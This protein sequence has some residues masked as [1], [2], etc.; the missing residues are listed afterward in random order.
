LGRLTATL[1]ETPGSGTG[2]VRWAY[3]VNNDLLQ[4]LGAG[5]TLTETWRVSVGANAESAASTGAPADQRE[6]QMALLAGGG[7]VVTWTE[8]RPGEDYASVF[9]RVFGTDGAPAGA[10]FRVNTTVP[11]IGAHSPSVAALSGGGFVVVWQSDGDAGALPG[12]GG[13]FSYGV[14]GQVFDAGGAKLGGEF[15]ANTSVVGNQTAPQAVAL[16]DDRFVV[17]WTS[18][19]ERIDRV[20]EAGT[21]ELYFPT[22]LQGQAFRAGPLGAARAIDPDSGAPAAEFR[23]TPL[24]PPAGEALLPGVE[25]STTLAL[26]D[27]GFVTAW[28][29]TQGAARF[30]GV[31]FQAYDGLGRPVGG[32]V[33]ANLEDGAPSSAAQFTALG[34]AA[35][36][37]GGF[38]LV[39]QRGDG[40]SGV[41]LRV[42]EAD[43]SARSAVVTIGGGAEFVLPGAIRVAALADGGFV[44]VWTGQNDNLVRG[45]VFSADGDAVG[46]RFLADAGGPPG[47]QLDPR[48]A[49]TAEGGFVLLWSEQAGLDVDVYAQEFDA[50]GAARAPGFPVNLQTPGAQ[51]SAEIIALPDGGFAATWL[52]H[53][54]AGDAVLGRVVDPGGAA[55]AATQLVTVTLNGVNDAPV[56]EALVLGQLQE[57]GHNVAGAATLFDDLSAAGVWTDAD[58]GEAQLLRVVRAGGGGGPQAALAFDTATGEAAVQGTYGRLFIRADGGLRYVLDQGDA[59]TQ[60]LFAGQVAQEV[61]AYTVANGAGAGN[62]AA[63]TLTVRVRGANDAPTATADGAAMVLDA[64]AAQLAGPV[65]RSGTVADKVS[66][67]DAGQTAL[68]GVFRASAQGAPTAKLFFGASGEAAVQGTYGTLFI[69]A[70]GAWRYLLDPTDPDTLALAAGASATD[71][72]SYTVL[73]GPVAANNTS[74]GNEATAGIAIGIRVADTIG[75]ERAD[76]LSGNAGA[77][78]LSGLGGADTLL[79][80]GGADTLLGGAGDDTLDGGAGRDS[81]AGGDGNDAYLVDQGDDA[82][83]ELAGGGADTVFSSVNYT[84]AAEVENL[85]LTGDKDI[86]GAGNGLGNALTGNGAANA[87]F[88]QGGDDTLSGG[89]DDDTLLGG[90]G[91]DAL[92]GGADRDSLAGGAG[93]DTLSGGAGRDSMA[94]GAGDDAY[95]VERGDDE[96]VEAAGGGT[97]TVFSSVSYAL[98]AE[99]EKLVLTGA[100]AINGAGNGLANALTGNGAANALYGQGGADTLSGGAGADTLSGGAGDDTLLGDAGN[101][102]LDGGAGRDGMAGG[103]GDDAYR[104]DRGDDTAVE[105]AGGGTDTVFSSVSYTLAAEIENLALTGSAAVNGAGNGLGNALAGNGAANALFG[106]GGDDT[107]S[108]GAGADTLSGGAGRDSFRYGTAAEGGDAIRGFSAADDTMEI[109]AAGFGGGLAPGALAA[110]QFVLG[111]AAT[112]A[113]GQ[114][115][116]AQSSGRLSWDADGTGA[117]AAVLLAT[118]AGGPTLTLADIQ[119]I[120]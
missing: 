62:E 41:A 39:W 108:G 81:M 48:V 71:G 36:A 99:V 64:Q 66:D 87:L 3:E 35:L 97:D 45:Q 94:G 13:A 34:A 67:P 27:G 15:Q 31:G 46:D 118:L 55:G 50:D 58:A 12:R 44:V 29:W 93:N 42:F 111:T 90:D 1:V 79:G 14:T 119:I 102:T 86:N 82:A 4:Q 84:L 23:I 114:F 40:A 88:G 117:G 59:D 63:S 69:Q 76:R 75:A 72:F 77:N 91:A 52:S 104:V 103:H 57:S 61:F 113:S 54:L 92:D 89:A 7:Y 9:A 70:N 28:S 16:A 98:V 56:A 110:G 21:A 2:T 49:G 22:F 10:D 33:T 105:L 43:G 68:L 85:A 26:A 17:T 6:Q 38:A 60:A 95:S 107:L 24:A 78:L 30:V 5:D 25:G 73:N 20:P 106:E 120:A 47:T 83:V 32:P 19:E 116:Y 37:D 80:L 74:P 51:D 18:E 112:A 101:D 8:T 100:A 53:T 96:V 65:E 11:E 115:L 109:S